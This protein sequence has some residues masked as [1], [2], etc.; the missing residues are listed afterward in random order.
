MDFPN[1]RRATATQHFGGATRRGSGWSMPC[2]KRDF[3]EP[4]VVPVFREQLRPD[5]GIGCRRPIRPPK[6][7]RPLPMNHGWT[8]GTRNTFGRKVFAPCTARGPQVPEAFMQRFVLPE[9]S[10]IL[11]AA[12]KDRASLI[13]GRVGPSSRPRPDSSPRLVSSYAGPGRRERRTYPVE[14][15]K[16]RASPIP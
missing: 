8:R 2:A 12:A 5:S 13:P 9:K 15:T 10:F 11:A 6:V 1:N 16:D 3:V 7:R 4:T 14:V